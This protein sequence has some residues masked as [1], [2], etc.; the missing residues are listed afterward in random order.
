MLLPERYPIC[1]LCNQP[2]ELGTSLTDDVGKVVHDGCLVGRVKERSP[3]AS[4][5]GKLRPREKEPSATRDLDYSAGLSEY[6][7]ESLAAEA[8]LKARREKNRLIC[9]SKV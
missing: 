3:K 7:R 8:I 5:K 2:V 1:P 4:N 9:P 6:E